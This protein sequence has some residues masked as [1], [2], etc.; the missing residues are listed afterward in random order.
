M[1]PPALASM[2][3]LPL[4]ALLTACSGP[5][6][7]TGDEDPSA[8]IATSSPAEGSTPTQEPQQLTVAGSIDAVGP[9]GE[10]FRV[11]L[12]DVSP[13][14]RVSK[15]DLDLAHLD[16]RLTREAVLAVK[17]EN[18]GALPIQGGLGGVFVS[19]AGQQ[20]E[21]SGVQCLEDDLNMPQSL[22]PGRFV[23]GNLCYYVSE[24][25]G[26]LDFSDPDR[27]STPFY[28]ALPAS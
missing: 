21:Y 3:V 15:A 14:S 20:F 28:I 12:V 11:T 2:I 17:V 18:T 1:K 7:P 23:E 22:A 6:D 25:A 5:D 27:T 8:T 13:F 19:D 4:L 26:R 24:D 16:N 9:S 10:Q